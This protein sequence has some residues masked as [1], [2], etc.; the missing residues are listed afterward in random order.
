[1]DD[2]FEVVA[3]GLKAPE[4]PVVLADGSVI[5]MEMHASRIS[6][7]WGGG[8]TE[9][10]TVTGGTP[11][12]AQIVPMA[13]FMSA[14]AVVREMRQANMAAVAASKASTLP[15]DGWSGCTTASMDIL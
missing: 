15:Q 11:N 8:R 13:L 2:R 6:R 7:V 5:V 3:E 12:G 14:A 9:V 1:M 4:G 10:V